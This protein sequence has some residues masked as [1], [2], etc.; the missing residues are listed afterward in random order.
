VAPSVS[1]DEQQFV[2]LVNQARQALGRAPLAINSKL[3]LAGDSHSYW[4]DGTYG[5][6]GLSHSGCGGSS[7]DAR[8]TDAGYRWSWAGEVTLV[9]SAGAN[10]QTAFTMFKNSAPH[11]SLLTSPNFTE[12]GVGQS[13][14][15]WTG[16]LGAP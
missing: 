9:H 16:N 7:P 11:W 1:A 4:Q 2:N 15:H 10:A 6:S 14:Y 8:M 5:G 12:I 13:R 3:S